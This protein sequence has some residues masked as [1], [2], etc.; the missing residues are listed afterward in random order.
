MLS[1]S[2]QIV[3]WVLFVVSAVAFLISA[4]SAAD[5]FAIA[6]AAAFL[7]ANI[8]FIIALRPPPK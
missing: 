7:L 6:G 1:F 3:G 2:F 4:I 5:P 8:F